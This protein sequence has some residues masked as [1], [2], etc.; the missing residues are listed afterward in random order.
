MRGTTIYYASPEWVR[1][2]QNHQRKMP[3]GRSVPARMYGHRRGFFE[4]LEAALLVFTG[5]ADALVWMETVDEQ[6]TRETK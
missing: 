1:L 3:D 5:R 2:L 6:E 4:R